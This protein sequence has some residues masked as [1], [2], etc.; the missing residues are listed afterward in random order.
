MKPK[1]RLQPVVDVR[2]KAKQEAARVVAL[3]REQL[4]NAEEKLRYCERAVED[5]CEQQ[6]EVR[7]RMLEETELGT[8]AQRLVA[9]RT[10]LKDLQNKEAELIIAVEKQHIVVKRA[11][12]ELENALAAL[13]ESSKE[14]K[15][16]EKHKQQWRERSLRD[17]E[18]REQKLND[19]IGA[20][21]YER[22]ERRSN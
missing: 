13:I 20:I 1:Y 19:E 3:R 14:L 5:C 8:E 17:M 9:Y 10:H 11:E 15:V 21:L 18:R 6:K 7:G 4:A 22:S 2:E 12:A 16:I